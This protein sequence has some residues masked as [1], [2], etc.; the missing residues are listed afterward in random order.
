MQTVHIPENPDTTRGACEKGDFTLFMQLSTTEKCGAFY[1]WSC[2]KIQFQLFVLEVSVYERAF[3]Y[4]K[5][6]QQ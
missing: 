3:Q 5:F 1:I 4:G 6:H 2:C